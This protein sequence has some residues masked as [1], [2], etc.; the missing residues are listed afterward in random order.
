LQSAAD[1][2]KA[3]PHPVPCFHWEVEFPEVFS[4][5]NGGFDAFVGNPPF[6]GKN[7]ISVGSHYSFPD[8]LK[9]TNSD[10][11]GNADLVAFFFRRAFNN[12]RHGGT[13]GLIATNTIGQGDTRFTG[14]KWIC[15]AGG[16][17]YAA[18]RRLKWPGVAAVVVSVVNIAKGEVRVP[19]RLD[20]KIVEYISAYLF[21]AGT[22]ENPH[23]IKSSVG[24]AFQVQFHLAWGLHLMMMTK[25]GRQ[26]QSHECAN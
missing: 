7:T 13:L 1:R 4:R 22:N 21:H 25:L 5:E 18:T 20:R 26:R 6:A 19:R 17:I 14:L 15:N 10:S 8:W 2:L 23:R 16:N 11:H 9:I 12:A 3:G 24:I